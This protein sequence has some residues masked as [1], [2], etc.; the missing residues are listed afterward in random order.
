MGTSGKHDGLFTIL[1]RYKFTITE[2][3]PIEEE[4]ALDPELL[5]QVFENLLAAYVGETKES[6]RKQA[7]TFYTPRTIV[8]KMVDDCLVRFLK[9][10]LDET[11]EGDQEW[12]LRQLVQYS[13]SQVD[14]TNEQKE[15]ILRSISECKILD[16]AC[17]SGAFSIGI[18]NKL[19]HI[20]TK[21]DSQNAVLSRLQGQ[22]NRENIDALDKGQIEY[23]RKLFLIENCIFGI[24]RE[25]IAVQIAR[26]RVFITLLIDQQRNENP[27]ENYGIQSLPN[28]EM[29][30]VVANTLV[31][32][33]P[34]GNQSVLGKSQTFNLECEDDLDMQSFEQ[35]IQAYFYVKDHKEKI[36]LQD[37]IRKMQLKLAG[38]LAE[39][40][41]VSPSTVSHDPFDAKKIAKGF[42][43]GI[44][45]GPKLSDGFDIII[46]NPPWGARLDPD[47]KKYLKARYSKIDS[48]SA[49]SLAYFIGWSFEHYKCLVSFVVSDNLLTKDF[50]RTREYILPFISNI[51]WYENTGLP[52]DQKPFPHV[53]HDVCIITMEREASNTL[54]YSKNLFDAVAGNRN[55]RSSVAKGRMAKKEF[56]FVFNLLAGDI[57]FEILD[58]IEKFPEIGAFMQ[59]H[60][61]VHSGAI[62]DEIFHRHKVNDGC[63][64]LFLGSGSGDIINNFHSSP[65]LWFVDLT[66]QSLSKLKKGRGSIGQTE[67]LLPKIYLTR[68]GDPVKGFVDSDN[69]ASNNFFSLQHQDLSKNSIEYLQYVLPFVISPIAQYFYRTFASP[70]LGSRFVETKINHILR[71]HI[72]RDCKEREVITCIVGL[73]IKLRKEKLDSRLFERAL[74]AVIYGIYF[75]EELQNVG[76]LIFLDL[77]RELGMSN[78]KEM[79]TMEIVD[80]GK[81]IAN[82]NHPIAISMANLD[83]IKLIRR[84]EERS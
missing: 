1:D 16:P 46:G 61:G 41:Q 62:R 25:P 32:F 2:N 22:K 36:L 82:P 19:V 45:F 58:R 57:D 21:L 78:P 67:W 56:G 83:T 13:E 26:L 64:P 60:E 66:E 6:A 49:N 9:R 84:I 39:G 12:S 24:D 30:F 81:R 17:G 27:S 73:I 55:M 3:T 69:Y 51:D 74:N 48:S 23:S 31:D 10:K 65:D 40:M 43:A 77:Q 37:A 47:E 5:G 53:S 29:K 14:F 7:G 71:F 28:L 44:M 33:R 15:L 38:E 75:Q 8:E 63:K 50:P 52:I 68:T 80:L 72:P 59:C 34:I 70:R 42:E 11:G 4:V 79:P 35:M 20:F 54:Q 76:G 18:L